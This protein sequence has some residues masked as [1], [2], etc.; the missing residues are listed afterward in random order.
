[1]YGGSSAGAAASVAAGVTSFAI[2]TDGGGSSRI[3]ASFCGLV[4]FKPTFG[5]IPVYPP[6]IVGNLFHIGIIARSIPDVLEVF[7]VVT[8]QNQNSN[9]K[10]SEA[11]INSKSLGGF[12]T[13]TGF[14]AAFF[15]PAL[16]PKMPCST[17]FV[18]ERFFRR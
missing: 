1:M 5:L 3:P 7:R 12:S 4:G 8:N 17:R 2:G 18:T 13:T 14:L 6:P 10:K 16:N 15:P 11:A 9:I